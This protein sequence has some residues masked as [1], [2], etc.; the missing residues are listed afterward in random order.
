MLCI[1]SCTGCACRAIGLFPGLKNM[2]PACFF[3]AYGKAAL[4][5]SCCLHQKERPPDHSFLGVIKG[6]APS[7]STPV[8]V[9]MVDCAVAIRCSL[10]LWIQSFPAQRK[11]APTK[12]SAVQALSLSEANVLA[13][14]GLVRRAD[15]LDPLLH[16]AMILIAKFICDFLQ[17]ISL[18]AK[19][20]DLHILLVQ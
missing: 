19:L 14:E 12:V 13:C 18:V 2:S 3:L 16:T 5:E 11:T 17:C 1:H 7:S 9:W 20:Q 4:F 6:I 8:V 10:L 15:L